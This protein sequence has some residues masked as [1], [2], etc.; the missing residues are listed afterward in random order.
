MELGLGNYIAAKKPGLRPENVEPR[1]R[2]AL[3]HINRNEKDWKRVI[4]SDESSIPTPPGERLNRKFV[5]KTF[6][7]AQIKGMVWACFTGERLGPTIICDEGGIG[8]NEYDDILYDD[9]FSL[10]DDLLAIYNFKYILKYI[11]LKK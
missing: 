1:L 5:K 7:S 3:E 4:W 2:W 9:L 11:I 8:A 6:K 10:V